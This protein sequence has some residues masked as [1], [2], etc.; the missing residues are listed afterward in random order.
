VIIFL[1]SYILRVVFTEPVASFL[2]SFIKGGEFEV[3]KIFSDFVVAGGLFVLSVRSGCVVDPFALEVVGL[4]DCLG[5][6]LNRNFFSFGHGQN[7]GLGLFVTSHNPEE[8][9]GKIYGIDKLSSGFTRSPDGEWLVFSL[10]DMQ[11]M[12]QT[13][14]D[15]G[16]FKVEVIVWTEDVGSV[17]ILRRRQENEDVG[18]RVMIR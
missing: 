6:L 1:E 5:C 9:S 14:N 13:G 11:F 2:D 17:L 15:V 4:S 18:E 8:K 12:D 16:F 7:D 10:A 3:W